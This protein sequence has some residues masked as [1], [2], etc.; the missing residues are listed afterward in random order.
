MLLSVKRH[1]KRSDSRYTPFMMRVPEA[2]RERVS[3]RVI[4]VDLPAHGS[5]P[6]AV[7]RAKLGRVVL[8]SMHTRNTDV[9]DSRHLLIRAEL[10]KLYAAVKAGHVPVSQKQVEALAGEV[11]RR[12]MDQHGDNP[13]TPRQWETF[14]PL[15][16]AAVEGRIPGAP[17][18]PR[19][20]AFVA[21][22]SAA[23][24]R[25]L[26][27][28]GLPATHGRHHAVASQLARSKIPV[29]STR[30]LRTLRTKRAGLPGANPSTVRARSSARPSRRC[31][32]SLAPTSSRCA[33]SPRRP[34]SAMRLRERCERP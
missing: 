12:L 22:L 1:A 3:G 2:V 31:C 14:K 15:T 5:E 33:R 30:E 32:G 24:A 17:A 8:G 21:R 29:R 28:S 4:T 10:S 13:G 9:A 7:F 18:I 20:T 34:A 25:Q 27:G 16:R 6:A 11:Y 26:P 23:C 19:S